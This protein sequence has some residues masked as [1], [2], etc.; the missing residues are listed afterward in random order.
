M[1]LLYKHKDAQEILHRE[2]P[3]VSAGTGEQRIFS[4]AY[5]SQRYKL[6]S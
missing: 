5:A 3:I 2:S 4:V 6:M 1:V